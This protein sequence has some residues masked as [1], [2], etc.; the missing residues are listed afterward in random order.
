MDTIACATHSAHHPRRIGTDDTWPPCPPWCHQHWPLPGDR[1]QQHLGVEVRYGA[2]VA[3]LE[4]F[5]SP[6]TEGPTAIAITRFEGET[7]VVSGPDVDS[8]IAALT[9][10]SAEVTR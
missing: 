7:F 3:Q 10:L 2:G 4:R 6:T 1:G 5:D 9:V 8:L